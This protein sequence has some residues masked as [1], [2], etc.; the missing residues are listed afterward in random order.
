MP[1]SDKN[2]NC[3]NLIAHN[4]IALRRQHGLSQSELAARLQ[5][6]GCNLDKH[7]ITR[8]ETGQRYVSDI[9]LRAFKEIFNTTYEELLRTKQDK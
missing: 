1:K 7:A 9:E 6:A 2:T 4:L 5:L 3:K 8:I